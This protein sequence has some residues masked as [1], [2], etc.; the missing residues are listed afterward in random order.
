MIPANSTVGRPTNTLTASCPTASTTW[1][2]VISHRS[3]G[4]ENDARIG[5]HRVLTVAIP[6]G[7]VTL[8]IL[9]FEVQPCALLQVPFAV[10]KLC[11]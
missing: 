7:D 8:W 3:G 4:F 5:S 10:E 1:F 11:P 2:A 9:S 6:D